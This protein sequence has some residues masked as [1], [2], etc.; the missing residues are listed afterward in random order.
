VLPA[1][2]GTPGTRAAKPCNGAG[3]GL[4]CGAGR[5]LVTGPR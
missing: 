3:R 4:P 5:G 2:N 1:T